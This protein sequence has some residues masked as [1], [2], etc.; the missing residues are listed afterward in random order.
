MELH[1]EFESIWWSCP[2]GIRFTN[3]QLMHPLEEDVEELKKRT[4]YV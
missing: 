4:W 1:R 2:N 3:E